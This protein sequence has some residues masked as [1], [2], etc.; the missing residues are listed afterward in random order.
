M[1]ELRS[2][3]YLQA[4]PLM[5]CVSCISLC[6][7]TKSRCPSCSNWKQAM[8]LLY[9]DRLVPERHILLR[10]SSAI[11][12]RKANAFWLPQKE[13]QRLRLSEKSSPNQFSRSALRFCPKTKQARSSL[14][15][16]F[17]KSLRV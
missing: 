7:I 1:S 15:L 17:R 16:P 3:D 10:T 4:A 9:R 8:V 13:R 2:E 5:A 14:R 11:T 6:P 12:W